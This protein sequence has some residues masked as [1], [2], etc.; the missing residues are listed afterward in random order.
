MGRDALQRVDAKRR[1]GFWQVARVD[2][3]TQVPAHPRK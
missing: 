2:W 1:V 3:L